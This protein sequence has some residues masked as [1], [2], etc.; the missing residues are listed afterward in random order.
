MGGQATWGLAFRYGSLLA[1]V[2]ALVL[3]GQLEGPLEGTPDPNTLYNRCIPHI[4]P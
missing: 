4:N 2:A 3:K 1:S